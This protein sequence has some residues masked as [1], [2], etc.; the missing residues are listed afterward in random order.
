MLALKGEPL[1]VTGD[2]NEPRYALQDGRVV[3]WGQEQIGGRW[4]VEDGTWT[5]EHDV[6][7]DWSTWDRSVR[8][9]FEGSRESG[10]R[11]AF[12]DVAGHGAMEPSHVSG[13]RDRWF[14]H[15]FVSEQFSV[16]SCEF[17]HSW[18]EADYSDHSPLSLSLSYDLDSSP[19]SSSEH[20]V[21]WRIRN[22][23]RMRG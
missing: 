20:R 15:A 21:H 12:W 14:D 2:F 9:F 17:L 8:W 23:Q 22:P 13:G 19:T 6:T 4:V 5:D 11:N 7:A 3:T 18:R 10:L 1:I 16:Q